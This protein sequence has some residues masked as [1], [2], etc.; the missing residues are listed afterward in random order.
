[1]TQFTGDDR[2]PP[3]YM[4]FVEVGWL[5]ARFW[6]SFGH[7]RARGPADGDP[8][9]VIPG[10][11]ATDRTCLMLR[12]SLAAEG[13]RVYPWDLGLN[14]GAHKDT[15]RHLRQRLETIHDSRPVLVVG[16]SLGGLFARELAREVPELV[17]AVVTLGTP[18]SGDPH[19][20][21][22]WRL[23][24]AVAGHKVDNPPLLH[25]SEK[26]PVPTLALWSRRDGIVAP[27]A[28][29]GLHGERDKAVEM[30]CSHM[31]F[32]VSRRATRQAAREIGEFL[33]EMER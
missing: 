19:Q 28:A 27:R 4:R 14:R 17:R 2:P 32:G 6:H 25:Q 15:V 29:R 31:A 23:Y 13:W 18:F 5:A 11:L 22:V 16:W 9:L 20:N 33:N 7:L 3:A 1:M 30:R 10:F 8:V 26:P 12:R 24:E 21:N